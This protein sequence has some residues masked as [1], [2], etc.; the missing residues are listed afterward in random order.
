MVNSVSLER[1]DAIETAAKY[2]TVVIAGATGEESMP[3]TVEERLENCVRLMDKLEQHGFEKP[4]CISI[5]LFSP[6][7]W[8]K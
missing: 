3:N 6:S 7:A 5:R 2:D 4:I 8:I 1:I